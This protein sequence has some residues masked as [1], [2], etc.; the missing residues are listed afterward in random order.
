MQAEDRSLHLTG[1]DSGMRLESQSIRIQGD[2]D[3]A[4]VVYVVR[5][6]ARKAGFCP[7]DEFMVATA[8]SELATNIHRYAGQGIVEISLVRNVQTGTIGIEL[9]AADEGPG[10][11]DLDQTMTERYSTYQGS[12]GLG[13]P[14]V[15]RIMDEFQIESVMGRGTRVLARKYPPHRQR[16]G[17]V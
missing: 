7:T 2:Q 14:S 1:S 8:A 11:H 4:R 17:Q 10:I 3:A 6:M 15:R 13:L 12:L 9:F 5:T 16:N